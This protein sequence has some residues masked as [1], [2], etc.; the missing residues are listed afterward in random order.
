MTIEG[1][2]S[3]SNSSKRSR[4]LRWL[5]G[6]IAPT[7]GKPSIA[8]PSSAFATSAAGLMRRPP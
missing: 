4:K 7:T 2:S 5:T 6:N 8:S 1:R 3:L